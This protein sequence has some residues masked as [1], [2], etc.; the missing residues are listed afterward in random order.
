[1]PRVITIYLMLSFVTIA[2]GQPTTKSREVA[3]LPGQTGNLRISADGSLI[4]AQTV[5]IKS[6]NPRSGDGDELIVWEQATGK[7]RLNTGRTQL[8]PV[9]FSPDGK[10]LVTGG[11]RR[12]ATGAQI[13]LWDVETGKP[14]TQMNLTKKDAWPFLSADRAKVMTV[15]NHGSGYEM[16][17]HAVEVWDVTTGKSIDSFTLE[18]SKTLSSR[19]DENGGFLSTIRTPNGVVLLARDPK[20][21]KFT[22]TD[23]PDVV[24]ASVSDDG[25]WVFGLTDKSLN[26]FN[27]NGK[28]QWS[29][30]GG[31]NEFTLGVA[32]K[33]VIT[34]RRGKVNLHDL[35]TGK[36]T[37][38]ID[39]GLEDINSWVMSP[40]GKTLFVAGSNNK[41]HEEFSIRAF[42]MGAK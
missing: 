24:M 16:V 36:I 5:R 4:A 9:G 30:S 10:S 8:Y 42:S 2:V 25:K 41:K 35:T 40:D 6:T 22:E 37:G 7:V 12:G 26:L 17:A 39:T 19:L 32:G 27:A 1:M 38:D 23:L 34:T 13:Q 28:R 21:G 3:T 15:T 29:L 33:N 20:S 14:G 11:R 31:F 18:P